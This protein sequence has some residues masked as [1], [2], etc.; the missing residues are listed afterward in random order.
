MDTDFFAQKI[1]CFRDY[2]SFI[3]KLKGG[4]SLCGLPRALADPALCMST[5]IKKRV[6]WHQSAYSNFS[7]YI[8]CSLVQCTFDWRWHDLKLH[9]GLLGTELTPRWKRER[10]NHQRSSPR[11]ALDR[12]KDR[13]T[14]KQTNKE[15]DG[16]IRFFSV[17]GG[18]HE[19]GE[20]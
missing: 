17:K 13:E 14:N 15:S 9:C 7:F 11:G 20:F 2:G 19:R 1:F 5:T 6:V 16:V 10:N 3:C 12:Q 8:W 4:S 18:F